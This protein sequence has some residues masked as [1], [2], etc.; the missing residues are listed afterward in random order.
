MNKVPLFKDSETYH[1]LIEDISNKPTI[2]KGAVKVKNAKMLED[3]SY[4]Y[5]LHYEHMILK[6]DKNTRDILICYPVSPSSE[7]AIRQG[8]EWITNNP[9][10]DIEDITLKLTGLTRNELQ[11]MW[12]SKRGYD[13]SNTERFNFKNVDITEYENRTIEEIR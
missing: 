3:N 8:I 1:R 2:V 10:N 5:V 6:I 7:R 9:Y 11:R 13:M 12:K 4:Y